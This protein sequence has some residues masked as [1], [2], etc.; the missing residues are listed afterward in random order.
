MF[1]PTK[2]QYLQYLKTQSGSRYHHGAGSS[3][4][5]LV[6]SISQC[7]SLLSFVS[8]GLMWSFPQRGEVQR[9]TGRGCDHERD[10]R[11]HG[12]HLGCC[13]VHRVTW[14]VSRA[15]DTR[16]P[17]K[18]IRW[19]VELKT[20]EASFLGFFLRVS[21]TRHYISVLHDDGKKGVASFTYLDGKARGV[22]VRFECRK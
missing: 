10:R 20:Y 11:R 15:R 16:W 19:F 1:F 21:S 4:L 18:G 5:F 14:Q 2:Y 17:Y 12:R 3:H 6:V 22:P 8:V 13:Y 7:L 9:P